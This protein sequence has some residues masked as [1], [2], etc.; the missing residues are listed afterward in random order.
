MKW[1]TIDSR[2]QSFATRRSPVLQ[3]S[4]LLNGWR[5]ACH[6]GHRVPRYKVAPRRSTELVVKKVF[7]C[8]CWRFTTFTKGVG[9]EAARQI[10][11]MHGNVWQV[12]N[13][14][15]CHASLTIVNGLVRRALLR[16]SCLGLIGLQPIKTRAEWDSST[17]L[18]GRI[19]IQLRQKSAVDAD[20]LKFAPIGELT[21][22]H[23]SYARRKIS[24]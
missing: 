7:D 19:T 20:W 21:L 15:H 6:R 23:V 17:V 24:F 10:C 11:I 22:R 2:Y 5:L 13:I 9:G 16:T 1:I 3:I 18:I 14:S 8:W 12:W 4:R